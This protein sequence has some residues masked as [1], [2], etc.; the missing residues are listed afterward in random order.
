LKESLEAL[1]SKDH[2]IKK[3]RAIKDQKLE[4][5]D[6]QLT[7]TKEQLEEQYRQHDSMV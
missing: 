3:E 2:E 4:F 6:M 5:L 7:E 1:K